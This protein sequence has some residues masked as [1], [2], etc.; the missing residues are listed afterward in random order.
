MYMRVTRGRP[1]PARGH[2][3][4]KLAPDIAAAVSFLARP[5]DEAGER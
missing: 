4:G 5:I 2:E 1:D 3:V